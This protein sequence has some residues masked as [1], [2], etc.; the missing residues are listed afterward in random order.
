MKQSIKSRLISIL[1]E[2]SSQDSGQLSNEKCS[3][4]YKACRSCG[5]GHYVVFAAARKR[6][7]TEGF[8]LLIY[9]KEFLTQEKIAMARYVARGIKEVF[10]KNML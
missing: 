2:P 5:L 9:P 4:A 7:K 3:N 1:G 10:V 6:Y 8:E